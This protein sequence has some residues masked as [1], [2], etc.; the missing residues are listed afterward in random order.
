[1]KLTCPLCGDYEGT[2]QQVQAHISS[3]NDDAH[4]GKVGHNVLVAPEGQ[5]QGRQQPQA[6][7][8]PNGQQ[9]GAQAGQNGQQ[10]GRKK[11]PGRARGKE[12]ELPDVQC[13]NCGRAVKYPE[14]M[15]YKMSCP[16]C[17]RTMRKKKAAKQIEEKADE[18]GKDETVDT[19]E[20]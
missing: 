9:N 12:G 6:P 15:P 11:R 2:H 20:V 17:G 1:M 16:E 5:Q 14:M 10:D 3:K 8:G 4:K 7:Q 19:A 13:K 18:K